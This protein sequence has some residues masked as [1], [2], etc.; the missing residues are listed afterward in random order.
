MS[1]PTYLLHVRHIEVERTGS[2]DYSLERRVRDDGFV[3]SILLS[4]V[5]DDGK[6]K[7]V[8]VEAG[9]SLLDLVGLC[10]RANS[11]DDTV[12]T[13]EEDIEDVGGDEARASCEKYAGHCEFVLVGI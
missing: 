10:L 9:V 2:V 1:L 4:N 7:L 6:V 13:L 11:G 8:R 12:T 3:E 5:F